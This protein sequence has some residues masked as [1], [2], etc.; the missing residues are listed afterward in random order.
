VLEVA[1]SL[2]VSQS[3]ASTFK[4]RIFKKLNVAS[5][6]ELNQLARQFGLADDNSVLH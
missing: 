3:T 5:L 4:G 1:N 2:D 6:L